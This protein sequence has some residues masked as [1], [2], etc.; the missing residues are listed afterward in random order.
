MRTPY[1]RRSYEGC[2]GRRRGKRGEAGSGLHPVLC[3]LGFEHGWSPA[4]CSEIARQSV[5]SSSYEEASEQLARQGLKLDAQSIGRIA[6]HLGHS[7]LELRK[8][9]VE[10]A[11]KAPLPMTSNLSGKRVRISLDGGRVRIRR[12]RH[13][14]GIRPGENNRR[15]FDLAWQEPR[16]LTVD[17][18]DENGEMDRRWR[19]VYETTLADADGTMRLLVG[20]LRLLGVHLAARVLFVADGAEWIWRRI[21]GI[22]FDEVGVKPERVFLALDYYHA[23]EHVSEALALCH[24]LSA[25]ARA[26]SLDEMRRMLLKPGGAEQVIQRLRSLARGRRAR[27]GIHPRSAAAR[28]AR[29]RGRA[30]A[31]PH[32]RRGHA[33]VR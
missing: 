25:D 5:L 30:H 22:L 6:A 3:A 8:D 12:T 29:P 13:G 11:T 19:P 31:A 17:V 32:G 27:A 26:A 16:V 20:T 4:S 24:D 23:T 2:R 21:E 1:L 7:A 18:L 14:R 9:S 10:R 28:P 15:P 33:V